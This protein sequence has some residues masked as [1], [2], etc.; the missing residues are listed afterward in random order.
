MIE[1]NWNLLKNTISN[2]GFE[3]IQIFLN[4]ISQKLFDLI[5]N[6]KNFEDK[7]NRKTFEDELN[8]IIEDTIQNKNKLIN[9]YIAL[10][11]ELFS[12]DLKSL[13]SII[14]ESNNPELYEFEEYP[15]LEYFM[16]SP[17][18]NKEFFI[19][20][21]QN[22]PT[23]EDKFPVISNYINVSQNFFLKLLKNI[24]NINPFINFMID[25]YS[26]KISREEGKKKLIKDELSMIN[27][28]NNKINLLF[29]N[30]KKGW[31]NVYKE[32][33][34]YKCRP[35][36]NP[37]EINQN[38]LISFVLNDD[39]ELG[40]GMYIAAAYQN[41]IEYQNQFLY[42]IVNNTKKES[43]LYYLIEN[44]QK[45]EVISQL[46][47][48]NE[49]VNLDINLENSDYCNFEEMI[50]IFVEKI[51]LQKMEKLIIQIINKLNLILML[52][53]KN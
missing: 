32:A 53:K 4:I 37:K 25:Y 50:K 33:I 17:V 18:V 11:N 39:G 40:N 24:N 16:I 51:V 23:N 30:F 20:N 15:F 41:F 47:K 5:E 22:D 19:K 28:V 12:L 44:I 29:E 38:D 43:P 2:K 46:A 45:E 48:E 35:E 9:K 6:S 8:K 34:K 26:Y 42:S 7:N 3:K 49:V 27:N 10:N 13:K 21:F 1:I 14:Q 31:E 52:L 36:M